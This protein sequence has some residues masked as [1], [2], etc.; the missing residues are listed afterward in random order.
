ML[1]PSHRPPRSQAPGTRR[2]VQLPLPGQARSGQVRPGQAAV[3][4]TPTSPPIRRPRSSAIT[5]GDGPAELQRAPKPA[6]GN[7]YLKELR[8][9]KIKSR[10]EEQEYRGI[11]QPARTFS[12]QT[13]P[14]S[15]SSSSSQTQ[16][17]RPASR[18][19]PF[20]TARVRT[21]AP[22]PPTAQVSRGRG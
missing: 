14:P 5:P 16:S 4:P 20:V 10:C 8:K 17:P 22:S 15:S 6:R 3:P 21:P 11:P 7:L 1:P 19:P 12:S 13:Q 18:P 9:K 2:A